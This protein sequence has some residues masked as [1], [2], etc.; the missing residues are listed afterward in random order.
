MFIIAFVLI[1]PM[2]AAFLDEME[3]IIIHRKT[4]KVTKD[5]GWFSESDMKVEL[6]WNPY[7]S[8]NTSGNKNSFKSKYPRF[9]NLKI[10]SWLRQRIAGAKKVCEEKGDT[11]CRPS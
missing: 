3:K 6:K 4:V 8:H 9:P 2:K 10:F 1:S 5:E 11:F 7:P